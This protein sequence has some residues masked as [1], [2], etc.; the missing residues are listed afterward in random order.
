MQSASV[1]NDDLLVN[2]VNY[3]VFSSAMYFKNTNTK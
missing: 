3:K 2:P 1:G